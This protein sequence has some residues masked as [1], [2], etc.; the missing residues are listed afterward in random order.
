MSKIVVSHDEF[1]RRLS[2]PLEEKIKWAKQVIVE[3]WCEMHEKNGNKGVYIS[4]SGG[5]DSQVLLHLV[6]SI[7]PNVPAVF[8]DTKLEFPEIRKHVKTFENVIWLKPTKMYKDVVKDEGFAVGSKK[9]ARMISDL[10]NPTPTNE[11]SRRLY[12][13]GVKMDGSMSKSFKLP[14]KWLKLENAP[15]KVSGKCCDYFKKE[16][17]R[18]YEQET[19]K[20]P[21]VGTTA[22]ESAMRRMSYMQTGCNSF[23]EN[24]KSRPLSIWTEKDIW[25]YSILHNFKFCEVYYDR[26][27][28]N[29]LKVKGESRTGC[30]TCLFG[31]TEEKGENRIQRLAKTHPKMH[32]YFVNETGIK[33]VLNYIKV[34][35]LPRD[36][37]LALF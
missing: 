15:F 12:S 24:P 27:L 31:I 17:F 2:L 37:Q 33:E 36:E 6:R 13:T 18:I 32:D 16:P 25:D 4:F 30:V 26:T 21:F 23:G 10:Q 20:V 14:A 1:Q 8:A 29:G 3:Y 9:I 34:P 28:D 19:G 35:Y 7:F 22:E 11:N 5:K